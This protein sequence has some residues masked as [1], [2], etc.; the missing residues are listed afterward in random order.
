MV[1]LIEKGVA[2][3]ETNEKKV[4]VKI[5]TEEILPE[6]EL[7]GENSAVMKKP[8]ETT[9]VDVLSL[10]PLLQSIYSDMAV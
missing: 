2:G 7:T 3:K 5:S 9:D 10:P 1:E 4:V 6:Q 8:L